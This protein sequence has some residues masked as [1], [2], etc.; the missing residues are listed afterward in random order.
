MEKK[1]ISRYMNIVSMCH[2][3]RINVHSI[4]FMNDVTLIILDMPFIKPDVITHISKH[5]NFTLRC[6]EVD[7]RSYLAI[8][9]HTD[10]DNES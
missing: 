7:D 5:Y 6:C 4:R 9:L 2:H 1:D 3:H 10:D 8:H